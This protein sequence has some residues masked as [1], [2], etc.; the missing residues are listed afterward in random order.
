MVY[1]RTITGGLA[2]GMLAL[3]LASCGDSKDKQEQA[4]AQESV[5]ESALL[6][7]A[8]A[9]TPYV[10]TNSRPFPRSITEKLLANANADLARADKEL[11]E[12][13][14]TEELDTQEAK[15]LMVLF[16]AVTAELQGKMSADGLE[17]LGLLIDGRSLVY[18]MGMLPVVRTEIGDSQKVQ[19]FISR[20][21]QRSGMTA[22]QQKQGEQSYRRFELEQ[23]VGIIAVTDK[24]LV[25]AL[26]PAKAE[27]ELLPL[28][29]GEKMPSPSLADNDTF[30]QLVKDNG[31]LGYGEGYIDLVRFSEI[32]LGESQGVNALIFSA[33]DGV[34]AELSPACN[35]MVKGLVQSVPRIIGGFTEVSESGYSLKGVIET[36][37]DI[38]ARLKRIASPVPGLGIDND[39]M[40]SLGLALNLIEL[41]DALKSGMMSVQQ[42]GKGCEMVDEQEITQSMQGLDMMFNP[43]VT[44]LK[45]F[46][47]QVNDMVFDPQN[48]TP[49]SVD[50]HLLLAADD[51]RSVSGMLSMLNHK[52]TQLQ[53]PTDGTP[54]ALPLEELS[55]DAPA[56]YIAIKGKALVVS[57]GGDAKSKSATAFMA[58][59]ASPSPMFALNYNGE[60][61]LERL[62]AVEDQI[63]LKIEGDEDMLAGYQGFK[64]SSKTYGPISVAVTASDKGLVIEQK[65]MLR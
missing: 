52:F 10:F 61:L 26:L 16:Q 22:L 62:S 2:A 43:M 39:A 54:V 41:R 65:V 35:K 58:P 5:A 13:I 19:D 8:P 14:A 37:T 7:Y 50:A 49:K 34:P 53:I 24:Y 30:K 9:D 1:M 46:N 6:A 12:A 28:V 15:Q 33:L 63:M 40:L 31:Y 25:A 32:A 59:L 4:A 42:Q 23:L 36:S 17:S 64:N 38:A 47:L 27:A 3:S 21:E 48:V 44:G 20:V 11:Q 29:L 18:G 55:P 56:T 51:P 57:T 60:K 45:G